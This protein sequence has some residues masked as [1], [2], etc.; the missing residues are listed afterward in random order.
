MDEDKILLYKENDINSLEKHYYLSV[1][2]NIQELI[3]FYGIKL[4][5]RNARRNSMYK[6]NLYESI[7]KAAIELNLNDYVDMYFN[8]LKEH[9]GK[10][11]GKKLNI[12]KG[13]VY[14]SKNKKRE[15]L[16]IYKN[17]L[18]KDP[19][20]ILIRARI[21][22]LKKVIEKDINKVIQL[23]ND[24]LKEFPVDIESWHE[25]GEIY[26]V[27][28]LFSY[29]IYCFEEILLHLPTNLYFIL[30]CAEL[31][32]T[33]NQLEIS[34]KYFCLAIKIQNNNL[35]ALWGIIILNLS[36]YLSRKP[37]LLNENVDIILT[38]HC[39]D[40]LCKLYN[41]MKVD[42]LFKNSILQ[43]L[44]DVKEVLK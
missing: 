7:L 30:T 29:A 5:K 26:L 20:D 18:C 15:A 13:M 11:D 12:L 1:D 9:F 35:R 44:Y 16:D 40:R 25:L 14:E 19:C 4:V 38:L 31:H 17:Y 2:K 32:Y 33:I 37:K 42:L 24:H 22:N 3:L 27:N 6:W 39:I 10:L 21:I 34:S 8:K 43:Y 28:C 23:L 36:R 41:G